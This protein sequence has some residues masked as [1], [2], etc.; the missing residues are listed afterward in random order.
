M[1]EVQGL[2]HVGELVPPASKE[3]HCLPAGDDTVC[4]V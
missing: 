1:E 2:V 3:V 4:C